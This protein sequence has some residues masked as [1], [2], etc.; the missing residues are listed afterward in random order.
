[1][2]AFAYGDS[3]RPLNPT[4]GMPI[5]LKAA[6][7][8]ERE[9]IRERVKRALRVSGKTQNGL[10]DHMPASNG[11]ARV[12]QGT[13]S[14]YLRKPWELDAR[15]VRALASYCGCSLEYLRGREADAD[16]VSRIYACLSDAGK[17]EA[18]GYLRGLLRSEL[19][20]A[21]C[22]GNH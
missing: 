20:E 18:T 2:S 22:L 7:D 19:V 14:R 15:Q 17:V 12:S 10:A 21:E 6:A 8:E 11:R 3:T 1:M 13:L 5:C 16:E 9:A 4:D